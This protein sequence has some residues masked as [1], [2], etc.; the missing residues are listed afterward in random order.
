MKPQYHDLSRQARYHLKQDENRRYYLVGVNQRRF[1]IFGLL[2][3]IPLTGAVFMS[4]ISWPDSSGERYFFLASSVLLSMFALLFLCRREQFMFTGGKVNHLGGWLRLS[5]LNA[6]QQ[7]NCSLS[8]SPVIGHPSGCW[9]ELKAHS[10]TV[11]RDGIG[12]PEQ[13]MALACFL[14]DESG[15]PAFDDVSAWPESIPL[16][17]PRGKSHTSALSEASGPAFYT[18][19]SIWRLVYVFPVALSV[20]ALLYLSST[21][22]QG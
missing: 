22:L 17:S 5:Q 12:T 19:G 13:T 11:W 8:I 10:K 20:S 7:E 14:A 18:E 4:V 6:W 16:D 21:L 15:I 1:T 9:L 3:L 2:C